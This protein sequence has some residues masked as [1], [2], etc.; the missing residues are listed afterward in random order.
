MKIRSPGYHPISASNFS[1][2]LGRLCSSLALVVSGSSA[3]LRA[4]GCNLAGPGLIWY[5]CR[6]STTAAAVAAAEQLHWQRGAEA[7]TAPYGKAE[8]ASREAHML[9]SRPSLQRSEQLEA[10]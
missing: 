4:A 5:P 2:K 8:G 7:G 3:D 6:Y 10:P 1:G 9:R